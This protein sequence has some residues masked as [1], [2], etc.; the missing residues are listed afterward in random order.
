[1]TAMQLK[2]I[3][4]YTESDHSE[5]FS[6]RAGTEVRFFQSMVTLCRSSRQSWKCR[7]AKRWV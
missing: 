7:E 2:H 6:T 4:T 3:G 1:M 5:N